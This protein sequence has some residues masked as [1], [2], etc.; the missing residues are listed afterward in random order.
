MYSK[1]V[2][3]V[4]RHIKE[5]F[6]DIAFRE[7]TGAWDLMVKAFAILYYKFI[8][9][10][11]AIRKDSDPS[12]YESMSSTA[13][14]KWLRMYFLTRNQGDYAYGN[15]KI[16]FKTP[17]RID[18]PSS[19]YVST[20]SGLK[21][22]TLEAFSFSKAQVANN[23]VNGEYYVEITVYAEKTGSEYNIE[24]HSISDIYS[25]FYVSWSRVD[26]EH[27]FTQGVSGETNAEA[28]YRAVNSINTRQRLITKGS[29]ATT[30]NEAFP[31]LKNVTILGYGDDGMERD[32]VYSIVGNNGQVP[33]HR[34]DLYNKRRSELVANSSIARRGAYT[35]QT[36][37]LSVLA[38]GY[39]YDNDDYS[40][41]SAYDLNY[42]TIN[43]GL[44]FSDSFNSSDSLEDWIV[45]D[46]GLEFG[47]TAYGN[48]ATVSSSGNLVLGATNVIEL[49]GGL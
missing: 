32:I 47:E 15:V 46:S 5:Y 40:Q 48:S 21:F 11:N 25:P 43:G 28:Y 20:A 18:I 12:E 42:L 10:L 45:S 44:L 27:P 36:P 7:G 17:K 31:S 13:I 34:S 30:L 41:V 23:R 19:F 14:D 1:I 3:Y 49:A 2:N 24:S 8:D 22:K 39:E 16:Y 29:I 9:I 4:A 33:Y 37:S 26:N 6:P 35:S 38:G